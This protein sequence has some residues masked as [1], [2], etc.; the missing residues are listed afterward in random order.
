MATKQDLK[1]TQ[2]K[3]SDTI[4]TYLDELRKTDPDD[5]KTY[6]LSVM[7]VFGSCESA[8]TGHN[9]EMTPQFTEEVFEVG[10]T[11]LRICGERLLHLCSL[12]A[13]T[14]MLSRAAG[15]RPFEI[16]E[17]NPEEQNDFYDTGY[18][19]DGR[20]RL[21]LNVH[22]LFAQPTDSDINGW[23][24]TCAIGILMMGDGCMKASKGL[25]AGE[26][27]SDEELIWRK[28]LLDYTSLAVVG[29][30]QSLSDR[31]GGRELRVWDQVICG[32]AATEGV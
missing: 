3:I 11:A 16:V 14:V 4:N 13:P 1:G 24:G 31:D 20:A 27:L 25:F 18:K 22:S 30:A 5:S 7:Q 6:F 26:E 8:T 23:R 2:R 32:S 12:P 19:A 17:P 28:E 10:E 15:C 29:L 9:S 21:R